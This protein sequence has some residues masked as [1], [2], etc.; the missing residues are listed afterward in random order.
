RMGLEKQVRDERRELLEAADQHQR[1]ADETD[2][3]ADADLALA[4][5][6]GAER[7]YRHNRQRA[8]R[9]VG[10]REPGPAPQ[11]RVLRS[12]HALGHFLNRGD[13]IGQTVVALHDQHIAEHVAGA[14]GYC[15]V[16]LLDLAL[17]LERAAH[18]D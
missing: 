4:V 16:Q 12:E 18:R 7:K 2:D 10:Y 9:A 3:A 1:E 14:L 11:D 5:K 15:M 17:S 13:L 8:R 6:C